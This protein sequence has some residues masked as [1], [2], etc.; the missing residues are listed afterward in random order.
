MYASLHPTLKHTLDNKVTTGPSLA[1]ASSLLIVNKLLSLSGEKPNFLC[2]NWRR[3]F[4]LKPIIEFKPHA[5]ILEEKEEEE[6]GAYFKKIC[7][8][9]TTVQ[10]STSSLATLLHLFLK[11]VALRA[12]IEDKNNP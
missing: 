7:F 4:V 3:V 5:K 9:T 11:S 2:A 8:I 6:E 12:I 10:I 1:T